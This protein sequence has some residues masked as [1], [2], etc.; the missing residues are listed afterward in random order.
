MINFCTALKGRAKI[1]NKLSSFEMFLLQFST[2]QLN[3]Y[4]LIHSQ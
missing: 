1:I 3:T 4:C 2:I